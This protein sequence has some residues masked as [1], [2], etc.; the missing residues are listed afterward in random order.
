VYH[1]S[2]G[3]T[4]KVTTL[5]TILILGPLQRILDQDEHVHA[6]LASENGTLG[7]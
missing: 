7:R 2:R 5:L 6:L 3:S 4:N 1:C